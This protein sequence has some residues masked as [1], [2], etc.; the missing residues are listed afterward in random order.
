MNLSSLIRGHC[1]SALMAAY[2]NQYSTIDPNFIEVTAA[3]NSQFGHYQCN[4]A[5]KLA[6]V[7]S[8]KPRDIAQKMVDQLEKR[9]S[10]SNSSN[11]KNKNLFSKIEIA[12]PGFINFTLDP[13]FLSQTINE[14]L[15]DP[16]LG[17]P[18]PNKKQKIVI[19]LSSP[20]TAKEMHVGHLRSTILGDCFARMYRFLGQDVL[21]LNHVGD[22]GTQFGMLI[23]YLKEVLPSITDEKLPNITLSEL[24]QSYR[25][26]KQKFDEDPA[27]KKQAQLE[28]VALQNG[29]KTSLRAWHHICD[30]SRT[31]YQH[32]YDLLDVNIIERGESFFNPL[33]PALVESLEKKG[34]VSISDG[35]KCIFLEGFTNREGEP[36]PL[37]LQKADGGYNYTTTDLASLQYRISHDGAEEILYVVDA[38]QSLHFQMLFEAAKKAGF[39]DPSKVNVVHVAFGFVLRA[40]GKKFKTRSG[41]TE[42]L[43]DLIQTAIDKAKAALIERNPELSEVELENSAKVLGINAI[44]YADLSCH[45][46]SDYVF[47]YDKML[48]FEGNTAAFLLYA[49]VRIQSIQRKTKTSTVDLFNKGSKILL[50]HPEEIALGLLVCQFSEALSETLQDYA[51]SRLTEYLFRLAEHFHSFFHHCRVEGSEQQDSRLLLCEAVAQVLLQG[52][53][54]L[55]LKPLERM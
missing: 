13:I 35:A 52:F 49:Y 44:K 41:D 37:I 50:E 23:A 22:W 42:R 5:M 54:L 12:G 32:I 9:D 16:M 18:K 6:K 1:Q 40:D 26:S 51:P 46:T 53:L 2:P 36:L 20:N 7:L 19:D 29:D 28:V 11:A 4:S 25:A 47:S 3:T 15:H 24:M 17:V 8:E 43:I 48:R 21:P 10:T 38:G 45:R 27:F 31:A 39:Y 33:L 14:Q 30:I 34:M 55:G